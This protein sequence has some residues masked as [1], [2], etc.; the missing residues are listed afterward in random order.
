MNW[1]TSCPDDQRR[2]KPTQEQLI[3]RIYRKVLSLEKLISNECHDM[4][5]SI[6]VLENNQKHV[7]DGLRSLAP[8]VSHCQRLLNEKETLMRMFDY[9]DSDDFQRQ[10]HEANAYMAKGVKPYA[11]QGV[12]EIAAPA[13]STFV[14]A[15]ALKA[16]Y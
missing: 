8:I 15:T 9:K 2:K 1:Q 10:W 5:L 12:G 14:T 6:I 16:W 11:D 13:P 3:E 4:H 7:V